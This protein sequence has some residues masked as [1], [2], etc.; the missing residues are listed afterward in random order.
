MIDGCSSHVSACGV[1]GVVRVNTS[2]GRLVIVE[3][4]CD[5]VIGEEREGHAKVVDEVRF[6]LNVLRGE[7]VTL[8]GGVASKDVKT[9]HLTTAK[10]TAW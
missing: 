5:V 4:L 2:V 7:E 3:N 1:H 9:I 6:G 10:L 8:V